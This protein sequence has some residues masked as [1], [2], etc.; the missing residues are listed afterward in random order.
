[1]EIRKNHLTYGNIQDLIF[2][3]TP[4]SFSNINKLESIFNKILTFT[5]TFNKILII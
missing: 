4:Q 1:M 3:L 2:C 5:T